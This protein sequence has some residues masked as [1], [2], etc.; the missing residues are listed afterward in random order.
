MKTVCIAHN[1]S[2]YSVSSMSVDL[3]HELALL[4]YKV[5][6]ISHKPY[7]EETKY[8]KMGA[9]EIILL[10]WPTKER[11]TTYADF[12]WFVSIYR[13]YRPAII[14]GHFAGSTITAIVS[15][16]L[17]FGKSKNLIYYHTLSGQI[18]IDDNKSIFKQKILRLRKSFFYNMFANYIICPSHLAEEDL[19]KIFH[20]NNG[21]VVLNPM[22]DRS[23]NMQFARNKNLGFLGRL[24]SSKGVEM[25]LESFIKY[26]T[27]NKS[28]ELT[29]SFAGAGDCETNIRK[30]SEQRSDILFLGPLKYELID[31]YLN[32]LFFTI[33]PSKIDNLPTVG[34]ESLMNGTPL[35][36]SDKTGLSKYVIDGYGSF[37]FEPSVAGIYETLYKIDNTITNYQLLRQ[38]A[39]AT[40]NSKF[41]SKRYLDEMMHIIEH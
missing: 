40:Y 31:E 19:R 28:S 11:P 23:V 24:D 37:L 39:R 29:L 27:D 14:I 4:G 33:I 38:Q 20:V 32:S 25:L 10:S 12:K 30:T 13:Q 34:L 16:L 7:F 35:L 36:L 5:L 6:F 17:S 41:T 21:R 26:K 18:D 2:N 15:K 22:R 9:G 3:A 8:L 1:Y